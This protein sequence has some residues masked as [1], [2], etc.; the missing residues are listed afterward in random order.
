MTPAQI[1]A[2][3]DAACVA[4]NLPLN[5]EHRPGVLHYFALAASMAELLAAHPLAITDDPAEAFVPVSPNHG[6]HA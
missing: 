2:Y 5:A 3:V 1:E 6:N 4:L